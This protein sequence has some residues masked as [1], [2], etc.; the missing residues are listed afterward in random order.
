MLTL[1]PAFLR[2]GCFAPCKMHHFGYTIPCFQYKI[3]VFDTQFLVFNTKFIIFDSKFIICT[4]FAA[5]LDA[6]NATPS[7]TSPPSDLEPLAIC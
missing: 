4:H 2:A 6:V 7:L 1:A 3:L 5:P